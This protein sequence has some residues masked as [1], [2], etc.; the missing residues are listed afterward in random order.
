MN[1]I[2][3]LKS[4]LDKSALIEN[5]VYY[6]VN[7]SN[8]NNDQ[9]N[10]KTGGNH[11]RDEFQS[12]VGLRMLD[13]KKNDV[14]IQFGCDP[15]SLLFYAANVS[16]LMAVVDKNIENLICL[17]KKLQKRGK[18]DV[19]LINNYPAENNSVNGS[20][21]FA[22]ISHTIN[23]LYNIKQNKDL[24]MI[25]KKILK[26]GGK[27][28][29]SIDNKNNYLNIISSNWSL[30]SKKYLLSKNSWLELLSEVGF[31][32]IK[33]YAVFPDNKFPLRIY[34]M[35]RINQITYGTVSS[36]IY[37]ESLLSKIIR[38]MRIYLDTILFDKM[39]LFDLSPSFIFIAQR[40]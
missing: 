31:I 37:V 22:I 39:G 34:P 33:T 15:S 21:D 14:G 38:K 13:I 2:E 16:G 27:L 19:L 10:S 35:S 5:G 29:F 3:Q 25:A 18:H 12:P 26:N 28:Y 6:F 32:D 23:R 36:N 24:L 20:F 40:K 11:F 17:N 1:L 7:S 8:I 30:S 9:S 4:Q